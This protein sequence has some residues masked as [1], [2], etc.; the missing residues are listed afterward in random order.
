MAVEMAEKDKPE[1]ILMD[2][3]MPE[4]N[5]LQAIKEISKVYKIDPKIYL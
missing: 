3:D 1:I 5:G 4:M 2:W